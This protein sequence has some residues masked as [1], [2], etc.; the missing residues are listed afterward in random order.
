MYVGCATSHDYDQTLANVQVGPIE[1]GMNRFVL[2]ADP[3]KFDEI[4]PE[5]F[6]LTVV[7]L[8]AY[9][10]DQE[11]IRIGYYVSNIIPDDAGENPDPSVIERQILTED[12]TVHQSQIKWD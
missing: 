1:V 5:D 2:R 11:F 4:P 9:Y 10:K 3:P 6:P 8:K 12:T 7:M